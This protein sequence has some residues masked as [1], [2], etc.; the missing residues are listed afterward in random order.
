MQPRMI[1]S[2]VVRTLGF[3][4]VSGLLGLVGFGPTPDAKD[5]RH[6]LPLIVVPG[7]SPDRELAPFRA[8]WGSNPQPAD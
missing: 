2:V 5:A 4:I 7:H 3:V 1:M 8:P 6:D